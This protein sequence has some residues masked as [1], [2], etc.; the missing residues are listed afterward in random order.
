MAHAA[1]S[2][3]R[4]S[5]STATYRPAPAPAPAPPRTPPVGR[6][7]DAPRRPAQE[8]D[9]PGATP[10][11]GSISGNM[12]HCQPK[13]AS[14]QA[15]NEVHRAD[16]KMSRAKEILRP[17]SSDKNRMPRSSGGTYSKPD[18][19]VKLI[20]A[21]EIT[22]VQHRKP[23]RRPVEP[24]GLPKR[25]CRRS[26]TPPPNSRKVSLVGSSSLT[27]KPM[28]PV[29]SY[30]PRLSSK[31]LETAENGHMCVGDYVASFATKRN[32]SLKNPAPS[33]CK[34]SQPP[35]TL[36][37]FAR[38][39]GSMDRCY[40]SHILYSQGQSSEKP[41]ASL[42]K[43]TAINPASPS[44]KPGS[45]EDHLGTKAE[46]CLKNV[47][48][49]E[50]GKLCSRSCNDTRSTAAP[51]APTVE[52][53]LLSPTSVLAE[54]SLKVFP[55]RI[56]TVPPHLQK[57]IVKHVLRSPISVL[58]ERSTE[59]HP[60]SKS[61]LY[62]STG[63][64]KEKRDLA[65][66]QHESIPQ[67]HSPQ[68]T[69]PV[70][71][72]EFSKERDPVPSINCDTSSEF[73][74]KGVQ[75]T[76]TPVKH[77]F[78]SP[79]SLPSERSTEVYPNSKSGLY[80]SKDL[81]TQKC[82]LPS[83]QHKNVPPSHS[84]LASLQHES[85]PPTHIPQSTVSAQCNELSKERDLVP[86]SKRDTSSE[87]R[88]KGVPET[89]APVILHTMLPKKHYQP[90]VPWKGNFHVTGELRHTCDGLEA[91]F[92]F[93]VFFRIYEVSKQMPKNLKLEAVPL[94]QLWPKMFKIKPPDGQDIGLSF[95]SSH[96][97]PH[98]S[99]DHLLEETS[100]HIGL[101]TNLGDAELS[102]F[103]S[104]LLTPDHQRKD[105]KFYF[106]GVFGTRLRKK[107][108]PNNNNHI[109]N[110]ISYSGELNENSCERSE[111]V[112]MKLDVTERK[113]TESAISKNGMTLDARGGKERDMGKSEEM[114]NTMDVTGD[115]LMVRDE[116]EQ[117]AS[118][119]DLTGGNKTD[120]VNECVAVLR[121]PDSN[122]A[123]SYADP[124]ASFLD[125]CCS[126]DSSKSPCQSA[127][128]S[129][130]DSA[131]VID[132][133]G[134]SLDVPPGFTKAHSQLR[135]RATA[136]SCIDF[137]ASL[138]LDT[139]PGFPTDIPPG[140]TEAHRR[141]PTIT[142]AAPETGVFIP[143][144]ERKPLVSFSLNVPRPVAAEVQPGI[145]TLLA[146]KK[147]PGSSADGT[148]IE[149]KMPS[150]LAS[151]EDSP[152]GLRTD[153]PP[154]ITE[155]HCRLPTNTSAGPETGAST[156]VTEKKSLISFSLNVPRSIRTEVLPG[157]TTPLAV[158]KEPGSFAVDKSIDKQTPS[159]LVSG[160]SSTRTD[161][162]VGLTKI[163]DNEVRVE[164]ESSD[165]REFPKTR[166]LADILG[167]SSASS[168]DSGC[169]TPTSTPRNCREVCRPVSARL[170]DKHP[171]MEE[172][173]R[174]MHQR[175]RGPQE[176]PELS[177]AEAAT[178]RPNVNGR[179]ALNNGAGQ[180]LNSG[181]YERAGG[182]V[183]NAIGRLYR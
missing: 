95:I 46:S 96:Q 14:K 91:R 103:S 101:W 15:H 155:A 36:N 145:T 164:P 54:R 68:P 165:E 99:F 81:F 158:K 140:F 146:V 38:N 119:L 129:S 141:R 45:S 105:G 104:K 9:K 111:E 53:A 82:A 43:E 137:S 74:Q 150:S 72:N 41:P 127:S 71:C 10:A 56:R 33:G 122:L 159:S 87:H 39:P 114:V 40:D 37:T 70:Q 13:Q 5:P 73:H 63:L 131:L 118:V 93:E 144:T 62:S 115:K 58:S 84:D 183:A 29:P 86:S 151:G 89:G 51:G 98:R 67:T 35:S 47:C 28:S 30:K 135:N 18:A 174:Q 65:S 128:R 16:G 132:T 8:Q 85:I 182:I 172:P 90:R 173:G 11:D 177:P 161:G 23:Y 64:I 152:P 156:P 24:A 106:W 19:R 52:S 66:L 180:A 168:G 149:K 88:R 60:N 21:E 179:I 44:P 17:D 153:V 126:R 100:S 112:G 175:K 20:P 97:G 2:L 176:Q 133:P 143:V 75:E 12:T 42:P 94:P 142:S 49:A 147:E 57:P 171:P 78:Q 139:P 148:A 130:A 154:R 110:I 134:F 170:P 163:R 124:A 61:V 83:L 108:Q 25:H 138:V 59:V 117:I 169:N 167:L 22:Y 69:A 76:G 4:R 157:F 109:K 80:S 92:P 3:G 48:A 79:I 178:K 116:I 107:R 32:A 162:K 50:N 77:V 166:L 34:S 125:G 120:R 26:V 31:R 6:R 102:I 181:T 113:E 121:T 27:Q 123:S 136:L 160:S 1:R 7:P 55:E